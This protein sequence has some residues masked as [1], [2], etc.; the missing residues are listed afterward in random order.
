MVVSWPLHPELDVTPTGNGH[1]VSR[2][3]EPVLQLCYAA[4]AS[5]ELQRVKGD[6]DTNLGWFSDR[7]ESRTAGLAGRREVQCPRSGGRADP[8]QTVDAG[9]ITDAAITMDGARAIATWS[10]NGVGRG[11]TIDRVLSGAIVRGPFSRPETVGS[12]S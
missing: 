1:L 12:T 7:L 3:D 8:L 9:A 4:T 10:E 11:L 6:T 5:I 2:D